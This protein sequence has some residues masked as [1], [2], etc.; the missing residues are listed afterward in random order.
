M[1]WCW[2]RQYFRFTMG[3]HEWDSDAESIETMAQ[4]MRDGATL[5]DA[6]KGIAYLPQ[7]K[8]LIK[9]PKEKPKGD[10]P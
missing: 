6:Y 2:S 8:T 5:A 4:T 10:T 9:P 1:E 3:R 7:F